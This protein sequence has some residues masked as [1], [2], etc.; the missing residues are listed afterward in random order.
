MSTDIKTKKGW[1]GTR[2]GSGRKPGVTKVKRCISVDRSEWDKAV[3]LWGGKASRLVEVLIS[4]YVRKA[5]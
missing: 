4:D 1:G 2:R 3:E 5:G